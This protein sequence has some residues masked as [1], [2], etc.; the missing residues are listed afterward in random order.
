MLQRR[1]NLS[2][3]EESRIG[4]GRQPGK[5]LVLT[6]ACLWPD[7]TGV[8][9]FLVSWSLNRGFLSKSKVALFLP[10]A[11]L[12]R[13]AHLE[14]HGGGP[15]A[16]R[17]PGHQPC[18]RDA[19]KALHYKASGWWSQVAFSRSRA[20]LL[21]SSFQKNKILLSRMKSIPE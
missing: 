13:R 4:Q 17:G 18:D 16:A 14:G 21:L 3:S 20:F 12:W 2:G 6:G 11:V 10:R 19:G 5:A 1:R 15:R 7:P 8:L 9:L